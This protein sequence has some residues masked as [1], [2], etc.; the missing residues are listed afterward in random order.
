VHHQ[1][2]PR[3]QVLQ[4][5][6]RYTAGLIQTQLDDRAEFHDFLGV[7]YYKRGNKK[8]AEEEFRKALKMN[9]ELRSAQ[10]NLAL[11]TRSAGEL[12]SAVDVL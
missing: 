2:A 7:V 8:Q 4:D 6:T 1:V 12:S 3:V 10:L 9:P 5:G 11:C